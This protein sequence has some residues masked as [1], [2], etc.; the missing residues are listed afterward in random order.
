MQIIYCSPFRDAEGR[1]D[2][3][4]KKEAQAVLG[5][6][7]LDK[8]GYEDKIVDVF[9]DH[10]D[11]DYILVCNAQFLDGPSDADMLLVGP[12][13]VWVF[14]FIHDRGSF[15]VQNDQWMR[16]SEISVEYEPVDPDPL[17]V[18]RDNAAAIYEYLHS[19][20]L[21]VPWVN[22]LLIMTNPEA[23]VFSNASAITVLQPDQMTQFVTQDVRDLEAVMDETDVEQIIT[24]LKPFFVTPEGTA[25]AAANPSSKLLMGMTAGQWMFILLLALLNIL[26]LGGFAW[27]VLTQ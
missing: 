20:D 27:L 2:P 21:P 26:V 19:K 24:T 3:R 16:L 23:S 10:L 13:G 1:P 14:E 4:A 11:D 6:N 9:G 17:A 8:L 22:P 15:Q 5:T 25:S 18:A 7:W 12:N